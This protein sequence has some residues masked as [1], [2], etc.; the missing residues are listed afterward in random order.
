PAIFDDVLAVHDRFTEYV[1]A[2]VPVPVSVSNVVEGCALLVNVKVALAAPVVVGLKVTVNGMLCP[3]GIVTGSDNPPTLK[4]ELFVL[5]AVTVTLAP[6]A[7]SVPDPVPLVP[8]TTLPSAS[9]SGAT[10]S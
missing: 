1:G 8:T 7:V 9:V 4:T 3:T 5:A 10:V 6:L 2:G